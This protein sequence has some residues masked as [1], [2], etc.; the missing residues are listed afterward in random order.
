MAL[1]FYMIFIAAACA[2][3]L[4]DWRRGWL[5]V[6]ICGVIQD[7]V[8]KLSAG[9]PVYIS[10]VVVVLY[11]AI[12]FSARDEMRAYAIDFTKRF[13]TISTGLVVFV[14]LLLLAAVNGMVTYGFDKWK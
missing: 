13:Q 14:F 7:P 10:F 2:Y 12:L 5:L 3:A 9:S 1:A 8:R 11:A 6:M 4:V